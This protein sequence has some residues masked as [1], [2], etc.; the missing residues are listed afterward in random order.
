MISVE[1]YQSLGQALEDALVQYKTN[2][3]LIEMERHRERVRMTYREFKEYAHTLAAYLQLQRITAESRVAIMMSNQSKW[4]LA[5]YASLYR[6][7]VLVPIDYKLTPT[8]QLALLAHSRA[9]FLFTEYSVWKKLPPLPDKLHVLIS[10]CPESETLVH[11]KRWDVASAV[12]PPPQRVTRKRS[13]VACIVYSSGTGG[14]PKGCMLSHGNY[15]EQF[16]A[17]STCYPLKETDRFFSVLP[18]NHAIDF[19]CGFVGPLLS[20]ATIVHQRVLRPEFLL[21]T[22][23][24]TGITHMAVVPLLLEGFERAIQE[25]LKKVSPLKRRVFGGLSVLNH[26]LTRNRPRYFISRTLFAPIHNALGGRLRY[27]FCGGAM[28]NPKHAEFFYN[29]GIPVVIGYGLTEACTVVTLNDLKP[30]R[31]DS[32]G[33]PL[34]GI[35]VRI[36][37]PDTNG[38]G[39]VQIQG[40]IVMVGYLDDP[41]QTA[42]VFEDGWLRTGDQGRMDAAGHLHLVGRSK[43][44]IVTSGGK[45][46]YPEDIE[47]VF[48]ELP[49]KE[50]VVMASN[51]VWPTTKLGKDCLLGVVR[52]Q[53]D[54]SLFAE[55]LRVKNLLL[56]DY[57]RLRGLVVWKEDFPRTAS[58]KL[59]RECLAEQMRE[60]LTPD[61]VQ[62]L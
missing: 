55:A 26:L 60:C 22:M 39:E 38:V 14:R 21:D 58:L 46:V 28:V 23:Q 5:A 44:M 35:E 62:S 4:L 29:L 2:S 56:P 15:L 18:T 27:V 47:S 53:E 50:F 24:R 32:V 48:E 6:G 52:L 8:E 33:C 30:F 25:R 51:Y 17:L 37:Q 20:G 34:P 43:N 9:E 10:D 61:S 54:S 36:A 13:D 19:M 31:A 41:G 11:E 57:K 40:P 12:T 45:N 59:K 7:A 49:C 3:A 16:A 1:R 42:E